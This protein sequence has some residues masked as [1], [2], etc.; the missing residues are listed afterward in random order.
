MIVVVSDLFCWLF[1]CVCRPGDP[2]TSKHFEDLLT[3]L[4]V[5]VMPVKDADFK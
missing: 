5:V 1:L 2:V 3:Q 4:G